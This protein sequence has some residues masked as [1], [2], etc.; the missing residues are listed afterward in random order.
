MSEEIT[1][2]IPELADVQPPKPLKQILEAVLFSSQKP[3]SVKELCNSLKGAAESDDPSALAYAKTK[4]PALREALSELAVDCSEE[5]RTYE[6]RENASGWQLV[7]RAD[8]A[9]WLR[10]LYPENRPARLSAPA[11]ETLAI[12]AYRQPITR[13]DI[14]AVRGVA[15]DGVMQTLLDRGLVKIAGRS[16][17]PG[18]PLL[19]ETTQFFMEHF[20][21]R[22]LDE[23]PNSVELR[24][25]ELPKAP[26]PE[27][28]AKSEPPTPE[29]EPPAAET[30]PPL[31]ESELPA[32]ESEPPN[33][34][35]PEAPA[36]E[37]NSSETPDPQESE[38]PLI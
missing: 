15:V 4:E 30:E 18:R 38:R 7:T 32:P 11:L 28:P 26:I 36:D 10:Q 17:V 34:E 3:M 5:G 14:E 13:A 6:V 16:E 35:A 24:R 29:S 37:P 25:I 31:P 23:L 8:F 2:E 1:S 12:I 21:L 33:T 9:P 19:Y 20:G 27:E 22:D